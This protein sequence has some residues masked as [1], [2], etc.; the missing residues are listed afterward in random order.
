MEALRSIWASRPGQ[1]IPDGSLE[2]AS[3]LPQTAVSHKA[4]LSGTSSDRFTARAESRGSILSAAE[5]AEETLL[6][7]D[8]SYFVME[9]KPYSQLLGREV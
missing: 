8:F 1:I 3:H 5:G 9:P 2:H 7:A 4:P 6:P